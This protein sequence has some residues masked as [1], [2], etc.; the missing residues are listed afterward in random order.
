[1]QVE[2]VPV[3]CKKTAISVENKTDDGDL[4]FGHEK[5]CDRWTALLC[6]K[7]G[8]RSEGCRQ[9]QAAA[10]LIPAK[11]CGVA[12]GGID[13]TISKLKAQRADCDKLAKKA[14]ADI[15]PDTETCAMVTERS[16]VF[17]ASRCTQMLANYDKVLMQLKEMEKI[18]QPISTALA[19]A[20]AAGKLPSFGPVGAKVTLVVYAD[21]ESPHSGG[22][23]KTISKLKKTYATR[24]RFVFRQFPLSFNKK[25]AMA[26]QASLAAHAQGKFWQYH[27]LLFANQRNLGRAALEHY[28][29]QLKLNMTRFRRALNLKTYDKAVKADIAMAK[30]VGVR[31]SPTIFVGTKRLSNSK[32][33]DFIAN[34]VDEALKG[35]GASIP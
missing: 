7:L 8:E 4:T 27:D 3:E 32:R 34:M 20:Q 5:S 26:A 31:S 13:A 17:P 25:A 16:K 28:A 22:V 24:V 1:V 10:K 19:K 14:C 18:N 33:Y 29:A 15:G 23:A 9:A 11:A 30:K 6:A 35:G 2:A 21:F 12:I